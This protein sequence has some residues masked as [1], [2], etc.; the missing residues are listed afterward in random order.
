MH[1]AY[2]TD[3]V[4]LLA[5]AHSRKREFG[6]LHMIADPKWDPNEIPDE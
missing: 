5:S 2:G 6:N 1:G 4:G 3:Q